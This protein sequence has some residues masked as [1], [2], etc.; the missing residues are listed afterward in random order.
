MCTI[1]RLYFWHVWSS[2]C[3][4]YVSNILSSKQ[5]DKK[6]IY[7]VA[8][9]LQIFNIPF[10]YLLMESIRLITNIH[11]KTIFYCELHSII[12]FAEMCCG[13][14]GIPWWIDCIRWTSSAWRSN[15]WDQWN[16]YDMCS[17]CSGMIE[18]WYFSIW[19]HTLYIIAIL[20]WFYSKWNR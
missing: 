17:S 20:S 4:R 13:P 5:K 19:A 10:K 16:W 11:Y 8:K 14:R 1:V 15:Y 3:M 12:P 6:S 9:Y 7:V 18:F 2:I